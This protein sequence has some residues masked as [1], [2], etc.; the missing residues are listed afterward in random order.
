MG[1]LRG[2]YFDLGGTLADIDVPNLE[3]LRAIADRYEIRSPLEGMHRDL[4]AY[5]GP[6]LEK[7]VASYVPMRTL[8][9]GWFVELLATLGHEAT[10]EERRWFHT[11][12]LETHRK[13]LVPYKDAADALRDV[14][15]L[16]LHVG[17]I[18]D[19]DLDYLAMALDALGIADRF[20]SLTTSEDVGVG[21]PNPD[22]FRAALR[23]A[24]LEP[25]EAAYVGDS[26]RR[27]V[28]GARAAG[29]LA[30]LVDPKCRNDDSPADVVVRSVAELPRILEEL[31]R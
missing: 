29:M 7:Q 22:I 8:L 27:D 2:V 24:R 17:L 18:S 20:D 25:D 19:V 23:K 10:G 16:G 12:Y 15:Q 11:T 3:T 26:L 13:G 21:K 9:D 14:R 30:I 4:M 31:M 1:R 6:H 28:G 5:L